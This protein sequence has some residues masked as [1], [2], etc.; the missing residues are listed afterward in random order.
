MYDRILLA[1]DGSDTAKLAAERATEMAD[2]RD[3]TL[4]VFYVAERTRDDP[5]EKGFEEKLTEEISAGREIVGAIDSRASERGLD[6]EVTVEVGVPH[7]RIERYVDEHDVG[8]TVV[9]STGASEITEKLLGTVA[10]YVVNE[11]P[12]DVFVVRPDAALA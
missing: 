4:H 12:S 5:V 2:R 7:V 11:A 3:A 9:G 8:L 1:T 6:T 10:K